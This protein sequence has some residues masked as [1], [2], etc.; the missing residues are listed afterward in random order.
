MYV[1][2]QQPEHFE[3]LY[4]Q[5]VVNPVLEEAAAMKD[6]LDLTKPSSVLDQVSQEMSYRMPSTQDRSPG[7]LADELRRN[8]VQPIILGTGKKIAKSSVAKGR[9]LKANQ[10]ILLLTDDLDQMPDLYGWTKKNV[11]TFA[12]WQDFEVKFKGSGS[13]VVNQSIKTNASLKNIKEIT[14]TLGD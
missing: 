6:T 11:Q 8:L 3:P 7:G 2:L 4:W 9:N 5:D 10:Q 12:K 13:K 1:T 14:I